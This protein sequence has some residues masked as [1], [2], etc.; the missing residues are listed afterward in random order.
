LNLKFQRDD[1]AKRFMARLRSGFYFRVLREGEIGAGDEIVRV[2]QD[3]NLVS[4]A[5]A[6][7]VYLGAPG[8]GEIRE[9]ALRVKYL[10]DAWREE[11]SG[12]V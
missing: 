8:S 10:S 3:E 12:Q 2:G 9:R 4:I 5:D 11:F 1:M 7:K 6:L